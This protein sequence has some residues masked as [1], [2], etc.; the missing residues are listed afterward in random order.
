ML[1]GGFLVKIVDCGK[2]FI[3]KAFE[4]LKKLFGNLKQKFDDLR[5]SLVMGTPIT[6]M[7]I[8]D[9]V[10]SMLCEKNIFRR[11]F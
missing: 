7:Y 9:L 5:G 11:H 8:I 2:K 10:F 6:L 4:S 3:G 1:F